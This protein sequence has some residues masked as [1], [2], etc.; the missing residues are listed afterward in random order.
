MSY[1][2]IFSVFIFICSFLIMN[3]LCHQTVHPAE[4]SYINLFLPFLEN[5]FNL[6]SIYFLK[7]TSLFF[8]TFLILLIYFPRIQ[9]SLFWKEAILRKVNFHC[10]ADE[11]LIAPYSFLFI[12]ISVSVIPQMFWILHS[13]QI[14][15]WACRY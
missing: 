5:I 14:S 2:L 9:P 1:K 11:L 3:A 8:I 7:I 6:F 12:D 4:F 15:P 13:W 10:F